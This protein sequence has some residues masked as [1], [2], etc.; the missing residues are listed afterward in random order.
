MNQRPQ[1]KKLVKFL[2][3]GGPTFLL[4]IPLNW[5][6]VTHAGWPKPLAYALVLA[7][8]VTGNFFVCRHFVFDTTPEGNHWLRFSRFT[9]RILLLRFAEW[10]VYSVLTTKCGLPYLAVQVGNVLVF[11][12][13]K[14]KFLTPV[15]ELDP[16]RAKPSATDDQIK[17]SL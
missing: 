16:G 8:Q 10:I 3:A 6:L 17:G 15:F 2:L 11:G 1:F 12:V 14:F 7:L 5:V 4:A 13:I 9:Q